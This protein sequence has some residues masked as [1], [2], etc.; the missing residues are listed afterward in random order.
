M[1]NSY[2]SST[3]LGVA[4]DFPFLHLLYYATR[5]PLVATGA[6]FTAAHGLMIGLNRVRCA[7]DVMFT[8]QFFVKV[9]AVCVDTK[10]GQKLQ[11]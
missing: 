7:S 8:E 10:T 5:Q 1:P 2:S 3:L 4:L 11:L 6:V 9:N